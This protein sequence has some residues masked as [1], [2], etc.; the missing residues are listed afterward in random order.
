MSHKATNWFSE[1]PANLM[2]SGEF[3]VLF[4]L[5]D[6]HNPSRGCFPEQEFLRGKT[7]LSNGGL[8]KC[9]SGL[10]TKKLIRRKQRF[11]TKTKTRLSTLYILGC[12]EDLTIEPTPQSGDGSNSTFDAD[13]TPLSGQ[14]QLHPSG[15]KPV[16]EPVKEP[17]AA[18]AAPQTI[19]FPN[20]F[21]DRFLKAYPRIGDRKKTEAALRKAICDEGFDQNVILDGAKAYAIEQKDNLTR[22]ISYSENW[23]AQAGWVQFEQPATKLVDPDAI[24][25]QRAKFI[26]EGHSWIGRHISAVDA[27]VL[28][29]REL[30]TADQC[31]A[32]GIRL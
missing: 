27:R 31:K 24:H 17:C 28:V 18:D 25:Q 30:V 13:P 15:D 4:F 6:C 23:V 2:T 5:A 21:V 20:D 19:N 22:Y 10:E 29:A 8:N 11:N 16:K 3:R 14:T 32:V 1:V 26:R 9:L 7:G 12:D